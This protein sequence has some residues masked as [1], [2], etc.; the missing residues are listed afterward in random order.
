MNWAVK[1]MIIKNDFNTTESEVIKSYGYALV[2]RKKY[3]ETNAEG[4]FVVATSASWGLDFGQEAM[5]HYGVPY[6]TLGNY[7]ILM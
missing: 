5:H 4:A 2:Q 3:Q 1:M 7:G 6:D